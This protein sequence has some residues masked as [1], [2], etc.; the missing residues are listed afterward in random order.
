MGVAGSGKTTVGRLLAKRLQAA[1]L[2][3]D[4]LHSASNIDKMSRGIPLTD[5]DRAPWLAAI[6]ARIVEAF[7]RSEQLVVACSAL[8]QKYRDSLARDV[9]V[10]WVYLKGREELIRERLQERSQHFMK[11]GMLASQF[12]ALEE[13]TDAIVLDITIVP[14]MA[15]QQILRAISAARA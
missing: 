3:G 12:A 4:S 11:A 7:Q 1:F 9:T 6:H 10:R 5:S 15:V 8:K 13:P 2:E 14:E